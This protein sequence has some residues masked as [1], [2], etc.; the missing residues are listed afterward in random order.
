MFLLILSLGVS[1]RELVFDLYLEKCSL[2]DWLL[3][4]L[5]FGLGLALLDLFRLGIVFAV[6]LF[7][8]FEI[9]LHGPDLVLAELGPDEILCLI[10]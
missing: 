6:S 10:I 4:F 2:V 3:R 7:E 9:L 8:K 1:L 5:L